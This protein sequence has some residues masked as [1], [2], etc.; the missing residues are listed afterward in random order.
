MAR[1]A[2]LITYREIVRKEP[3]IADLHAILKQYERQEVIFLLAKLN[4]L[5]GTWENTPKFE[6]DSRISTYLRIPMK[7]IGV[8]GGW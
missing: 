3:S 8:P 6:L 2:I 4:C 5:L 1:V 7:V